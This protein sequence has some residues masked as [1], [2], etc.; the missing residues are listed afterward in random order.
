MKKD[1]LSYAARPFSMASMS[2]ARSSD[3]LNVSGLSSWRAFSNLRYSLKPVLESSA[4]AMSIGLRVGGDG[5]SENLY[6]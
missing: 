3:G 6:V 2:A 5:G 1:S 4:P